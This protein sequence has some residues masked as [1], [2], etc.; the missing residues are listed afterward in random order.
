MSQVALQYAH[1]ELSNDMSPGF[2]IIGLSSVTSQQKV[3]QVEMLLY[4]TVTNP[5]YFSVVT[6]TGAVSQTINQGQ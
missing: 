1:N 3:V 4:T 2:L 6:S 5:Y